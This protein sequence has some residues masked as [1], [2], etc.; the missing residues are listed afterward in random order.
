MI[1]LKFS[2]AEKDL[3]PSHFI[4]ANSHELRQ[5]LYTMRIFLGDLTR[6][7]SSPVGREILLGLRQSVDEMDSS[8][9]SIMD[10]SKLEAG[11]VQVNVQP[12][13]LAELFGKLQRHCGIGAIPCF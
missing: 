1:Y 7:V 11:A 2:F 8:F 6:Y 10:L 12:L 4:A 9:E 3:H 13:A 5:P